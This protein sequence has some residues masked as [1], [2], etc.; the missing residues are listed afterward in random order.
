VHKQ[1]HPVHITTAHEILQRR[2]WQLCKST[3]PPNHSGSWTRKE[4]I[5]F[6]IDRKFVHSQ[7]CTLLAATRKPNHSLMLWHRRNLPFFTKLVEFRTRNN[8]FDELLRAVRCSMIVRYQL[9]LCAS[10]DSMGVWGALCAPQRPPLPASRP[11]SAQGRAQTPKFSA[12]PRE[13]KTLIHRQASLRRCGCWR[14][15]LAAASCGCSRAAQTVACQPMSQRAKAAR[16]G[17]RP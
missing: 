14:P 12:N 1:C 2:K 6:V 9:C 5:G 15:G 10:W 13:N 11:E 7:S 17:S 8:N 16:K 4:K 3:L